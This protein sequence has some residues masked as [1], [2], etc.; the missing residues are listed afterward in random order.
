MDTTGAESEWK[1]V[2]S[3]PLSEPYDVGGFT[4]VAATKLSMQALIPATDRGTRLGEHTETRPKGLV[5]VAGRPLLAY[6]FETVVDAGTDELIVVIG[7]GGA[8]IIDHFADSFAGVPITYVRQRERLGLGDAVRQ[9]EPHIDGLFLLLNGDNVF[10]GS[11]APAVATADEE[12]IDGVLTVESVSRAE[13][14]TTGVL[15]LD[16]SRV[17]DLVEKPDDPPSTLVTTSCYVLPTDIFHA[18]A[19]V[20]LSAEG[21]Y[22]LSE[23]V[24]LLIQAGYEIETIDDLPAAGRALGQEFIEHGDRLSQIEGHL[25]V[26]EQ[27]TDCSTKAKKI[28]TVL[29]FASNKRGDKASHSHAGGDPRVYGGIATVRV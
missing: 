2:A 10:A 28:A 24:G 25:E 7:Y 12:G 20:Q 22:Q 29:T 18:C 21:E 17:T 9:A 16:D 14:T 5:A 11:V 19:L 26:L 3:I 1:T 15:K 4:S 6:V 13:A 27:S 8:Q 23:A